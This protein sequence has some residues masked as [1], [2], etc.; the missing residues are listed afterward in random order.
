MSQL[1]FMMQLVE[2]S[3]HDLLTRAYT[4][5][6]GEELVA[7]QFNASERADTQLAMCFI[8]LDNFKQI[9]DDF[10]HEEGDDTLRAAAATLRQV[11]RRS[12]ILVRW[13]GEEFLVV[14]PSTSAEGAIKAFRRI[15]D[16]G[17]GHP[18]GRAAANRVD[19]PR[20]AAQGRSA[21]LVR[22]GGAGR[23]TYVQG[24]EKRTRPAGRRR[25]RN[26]PARRAVGA[27][28]VEAGGS[29]AGRR[30][31]FQRFDP[32]LQGFDRLRD[33]FGGLVPV[34]LVEQGGEGL[35]LAPDG[36]G[37]A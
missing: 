28:G 30:R 4:R 32:D 18:A 5:R 19:G 36:L 14:M 22:V 20:R 35:R 27:S 9:N 17:L 31:I 21:D 2:Q 33:G 29:I 34:G 12:D 16:S 25:R 37:M 7:V 24:Q 26:P 15:L 3:S 23:P 1:H 13:G 10:G 11:L 8:D 6:V